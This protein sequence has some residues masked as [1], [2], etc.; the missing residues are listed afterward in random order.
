M[1]G[2]LTFAAIRLAHGSRQ[3]PR[4][5]RT[6]VRKQCDGDWEHTYGVTIDTLDNPGWRLKIDL[7][8]TAQDRRTM[9][10]ISHNMEHETDW[11]TCWTE[12]SQFHGAGGVR[13]LVPIIDA[14]RAWIENGS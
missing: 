12:S 10:R 7:S 4:L 9:D 3:F 1:G 5:A 2:K 11:W 13:Q 6:L 8:G 14:F